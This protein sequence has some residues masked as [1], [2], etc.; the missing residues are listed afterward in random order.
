MAPVPIATVCS[1]TPAPTAAH[2]ATAPNT[3]N[4][5]RVVAEVE[6]MEGQF[7]VKWWKTV[8]SSYRRRKSTVNPLC[9]KL[10][11][12]GRK[13]RN[14][15]GMISNR[16]PETPALV[17]LPPNLQGRDFVVGDLHGAYDALRQRLD[18]VRFAPDAGDRLI[19]VGDLVDRGAQSLDCLRLLR[20][21]WFHAVLGNHERMLL[22]MHGYPERWLMHVHSRLYS[23]WSRMLSR[24]ENE[25]LF[26][27]LLP[28]LARLPLALRVGEDPRKRYYVVHA[29]RVNG[30]FVL[31]DNR[32]D[33]WAH[34]ERTIVP[35]ELVNT[36]TRSRALAYEAMVSQR[37]GSAARQIW[38]PHV[39][40]TYA[41]HT[42]VHRILLHRSHL[43]LD[44]GGVWADR[45]NRMA[46][47]FELLL[48]EH[49][50]PLPGEPSSL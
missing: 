11:W 34:T 1:S 16:G 41:G 47:R 33:A 42:V 28:R 8:W 24:R 30:S 21:P 6:N 49:G 44:R 23:R 26:S 48:W 22:A 35:K 19:A 7:L 13:L 3:A 12:A 37:A 10:L 17:A 45:P 39:S 40:L 32:L 36:V 50:R 27:D 20:E 46:A 4:A 31:T 9:Q 25:E 2:T 5:V 43:F 29:S 15:G 38:E 18:G 14:L